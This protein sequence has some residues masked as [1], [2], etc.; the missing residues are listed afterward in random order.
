MSKVDNF[1]LKRLVLRKNPIFS[2]IDIQFTDD[3]D[4]SDLP[5]VSLIIGPN[6]TGKSNL[7]RIISD[8]FR[9]IYDIQNDLFQA[10]VYGEYYL[11]YKYGKYEYVYANTT[12]QGNMVS[13]TEGKRMRSRFI[14]KNGKPIDISELKI[15][16]RLLASSIMLTDKFYFSK[17]DRYP[18]YSYL[19]VRTSSNQSGTLSYIRKSID[20]LISTITMDR[21]AFLLKFE[22]ILNVLEFD[23]RLTIRYQLSYKDKFFTGSLT[24]KEFIDIFENWQ[25]HFP[26]RKT[27]PFGYSR[28]S[29]LK[30]SKNDKIQTIVDFLNKKKNEGY[31]KRKDGT[32]T[33]FLTYDLMDHIISKEDF[34]CINELNSL[35]ILRAPSITFYKNG[36]ALGYKQSSSGEQHII[37][38]LIGIM[39]K[40]EHGSLILLDEPEIS[41]HPNWQMRYIN[42]FIVELFK[43][44]KTCQ[45]IIASHSHF[46][47]SDIR[48]ES[49]KIIGLKKSQ[50]KIENIDFGE[51]DTFGWSAEEV[52]YEIF[53]VKST[54]NSFVENDLVKLLDIVNRDSKKWEDLNSIIVRLNSLRL[55][56]ND[57]TNIII[58]KGLKYYNSRNA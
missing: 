47:A 19:G 50:E 53:R 13:K 48:G 36:I 17:D 5:Y 27:A 42:D 38:T 21:N 2:D 22:K 56:E 8:L 30:K 31:L 34:D 57:P 23:Y 55:S 41:L 49:S 20:L 33:E 32:R 15:P 39:S 18:F 37:T 14:T 51:I 4:E 58:E 12:L 10:H 26:K 54:R 7:L 28:Y 16:N 6:G 45:F 24:K 1:R 52:L 11:E 25:S 35:D 46:L 29:F 40:I 43:E 44:Y 3:H 9:Q